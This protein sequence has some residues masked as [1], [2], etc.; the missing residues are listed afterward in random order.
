M[1]D[2]LRDPVGFILIVACIFCFFWVLDL[3]FNKSNKSSGTKKTLIVI[4]W[5]VLILFTNNY[6]AQKRSDLAKY[7][8][9][10]CSNAGEDYQDCLD[11]Q[12]HPYDPGS[13]YDNM[14][15]TDAARN[16]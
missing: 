2:F 11:I 14:V 1:A 4:G 6:F 5:I 8:P 10:P 9:A 13:R 7:G 15:A 12:N 3:L 16:K